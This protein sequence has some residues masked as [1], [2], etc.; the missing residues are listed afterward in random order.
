MRRLRNVILLTVVGLIA[1]AG[2]APLRPGPVAANSLVDLC[3][4]PGC[5][6][7]R[8]N[9]VITCNGY[10]GDFCW[11]AYLIC[12]G[13]CAGQ[14]LEFTCQPEPPTQWVGCTCKIEG[15]R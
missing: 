14:I 2:A 13:I 7:D 12:D 15:R 1:S 11:D 10:E 9:Q 4:E 5:S 6:C 3:M 8:P